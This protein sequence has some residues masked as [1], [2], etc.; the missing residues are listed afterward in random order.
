MKTL[1]NMSMWA[2]LSISSITLLTLGIESANAQEPAITPI[3]QTDS[4]QQELIDLY[5]AAAKSGNTEVIQEFL[6]HGFPVD[7]KNQAG[8]TALMMAAYYGHAEVVNTLLAHQSNRCLRDSKGHTALMGA[9]V[10]GE[11]GIA[12]QLS[13][14][15]CDQAAKQEG[16]LTTEEFAKVF[17]QQDKLKQL[18][19]TP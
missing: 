16:A 12:K 18:L 13:K 5:F 17:G 7:I 4:A 3:M 1:F 8:F 11:W 15:D 19:Q 10:K 14:V 2:C 6:T 9:I